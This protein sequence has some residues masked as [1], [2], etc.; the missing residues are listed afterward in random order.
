MTEN[1]KKKKKKWHGEGYKLKYGE[2][3]FKYIMGFG[4]CLDLNGCCWCLVESCGERYAILFGFEL[5]G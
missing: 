2:F 5:A 1:L 3:V 4:L